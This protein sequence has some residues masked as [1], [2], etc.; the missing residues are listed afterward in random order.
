MSWA[1]NTKIRLQLVAV[2]MSIAC[3]LGLVWMFGSITRQYASSNWPTAEGV[4]QGTVVKTWFNAKEGVNKYFARVNYHYTVDGKSFTSDLTDL[5]P[6]M[7]RAS[8]ELAL[9]D[10]AA[11]RPRAK[12]SVHYDP[13]NPSIGVIEPGVPPTHMI[14][15]ACL[16]F[17]AT[18]CPVVAFFAIRGWIAPPSDRLDGLD[19]LAAS[20]RGYSR[21]TA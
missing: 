7:K 10:V 8:R 19:G 9:A 13:A 3:P 5:G 6:G 15:F 14:L 18:V 11:Y 4:V 16:V 1:Q 20:V 17:G 12:V 2:V 21:T